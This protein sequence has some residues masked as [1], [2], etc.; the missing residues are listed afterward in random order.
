MENNLIE[1]TRDKRNL[2]TSDTFFFVLPNE[3]IEERMRQL[4]YET[5]DNS[6]FISAEEFCNEYY[7][8]LHDAESQVAFMNKLTQ[9]D[10][11]I[12]KFAQFFE[13]KQYVINFLKDILDIRESNKK[14]TAIF[15]DTELMFL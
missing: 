7:N 13:G 4:K 12:I 14:A 3:E 5:V 2:L 15:S 8:S 6:L 1:I 11:L 10:E 9:C